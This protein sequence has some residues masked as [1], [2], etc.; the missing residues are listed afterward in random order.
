MCV[1]TYIAHRHL[2]EIE[3]SLP[4]CKMVQNNKTFYSETGLFGKLLRTGLISFSLTTPKLCA[5]RGLIDLN[6][7]HKMPPRL[8]KPLIATWIILMG[9]IFALMCF[10]A[11]LHFSPIR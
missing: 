4:N 6:D 2:D 9:L 3:S 11:W 5:R 1:I 10:R 7:F 8:K